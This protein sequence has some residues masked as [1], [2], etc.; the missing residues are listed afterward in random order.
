[1]RGSCAHLLLVALAACGSPSNTDPPEPTFAS[2]GGSGA[3]ALE[4]KGTLRF[5][6]KPL[7]LLGC[8]AGHVDHVFAEVV[9]ASGKL[10]FEDQ[11]LYWNPDP[12]AGVRGDRL[13]CEKLDRSWGGGNRLD[14]TSY[15]RGTLAFRCTLGPTPVTGELTLDCGSITAAERAQLDGN[16]QE[17]LDKQKAG[18]GSS[19]SGSGVGSGSGAVR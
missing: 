2:G 15:F 19:G 16:R 6:G 13:D 4:V 9:T 12:S 7:A 17:L 18:S 1:M 8:V 5:G 3:G 10:R 11:Q 14:G